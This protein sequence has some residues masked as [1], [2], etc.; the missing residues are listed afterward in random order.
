MVQEIRRVGTSFHQIADRASTY[1]RLTHDDL[2]KG[3]QLVVM[4]E[5]QVTMLRVVLES[6]PSSSSSSTDPHD[7]QVDGA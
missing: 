1:Q 3:A 4:L 7:D 5:R 2:R 6:L